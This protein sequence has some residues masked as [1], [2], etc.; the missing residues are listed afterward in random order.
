PGDLYPGPPGRFELTPW[1]REGGGGGVM[2]FLR[3]R[4][5][6]KCG[7]HVSQGHGPF[8]PEMAAAM[9]GAAED[10][11]FVA[12]GVSLIAHMVSPRIPAVHL[13]TRYIATTAGWFGGG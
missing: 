4:L 11:R 8:S 2:G 6:E 9:P 10:P 13:N 12:T 1:T 5:F 3:G 7:L